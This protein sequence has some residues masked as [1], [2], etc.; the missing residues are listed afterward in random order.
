MGKSR[1]GRD[2]GWRLMRNVMGNGG[3]EASRP[4]GGASRQGIF[5][6]IVPLDPA[7]KAGLAGH[8]PVSQ[9]ELQY[10]QGT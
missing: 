5:F 6:Y 2:F 7:Y 1:P 8:I 9:S 4:K 3:C 10:G